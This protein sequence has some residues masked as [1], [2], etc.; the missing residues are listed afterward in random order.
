MWTNSPQPKYVLKVFKSD[1]NQ[2]TMLLSES[3]FW[4]QLQDLITHENI[5]E[6]LIYQVGECLLNW[7]ER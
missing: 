6:F 3:E 1:G 5:E 2:D 7:T 4:M